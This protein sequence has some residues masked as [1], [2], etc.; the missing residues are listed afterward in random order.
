MRI[1]KVSIENFKCFKA[2][3][4]QLGKL[5]LLTGANSSGKSSI[6]YSILGALQSG[7]FPFQFSPNGKYVNMGNFR[8]MS[9]KHLK[10]NIIKI[11]IKI[12]YDKDDKVELN[13][14]W[15]EDRV[16]KLPRLNKLLIDGVFYKLKIIKNRKYTLN[17]RF[18]S[19]EELEKS[20]RLNVKTLRRYNKYLA[21][22]R[23]SQGRL[24]PE[25]PPKDKKKSINFTFDNID[26][27]EEIIKT[28]KDWY[29]IPDFEE[30]KYT[31][32]LLDK[33]INFISSFRLFPERTYYETTKTDLTVGKF[34]ED[35]V[36]QII[37]WET[38]KAKEYKKLIEIMKNLSLFEGISSRRLDG[39]R[40]ELVV[41][42]N[43]NSVPASLNDVG[44]GISQFLPIIVADLQ[45]GEESTLFVAQPEIHLHP[46]VQAEFGNYMVNQVKESKKNYIIETHSE[47]LLNRIRLA[48]VKGEIPKDEVKVYYLRNEGED[49][50]THQ[51]EFTT[52]GQILNAPEDFFKTYQ[53]DVMNIAMSANGE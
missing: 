27:I 30:T 52:D 8:E 43:K 15:E 28:E 23:L 2:V 7:E 38:Q 31:L 12:E 17:H 22:G 53:M 49:T 32:S 26:Q 13:T 1:N 42:V 14:W 39:G 36:N 51:L 25:P 33:R 35:Y 46:S 37:L 16:R 10:E 18:Y 5:T 19:M 11:G 41:K 48:I 4:I 29:L 6:L 34:G 20:K 47:Y 9:Y 44:F 50:H 45:L 3:D 21:T 24:F 40:F